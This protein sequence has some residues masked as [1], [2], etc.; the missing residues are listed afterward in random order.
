MSSSGTKVKEKTTATK[1][2]DK[3]KDEK[4][5]WSRQTGPDPRDPRNVGPPCM[6]S[7]DPAR[8]GRGSPSGSNAH[9]CWTA[10]SRCKMRLMYVPAFGAHA[11][12]RKAGALPADVEKQVQEL[13]NEAAY[14]S[15]LRDKDIGLDAAERSCMAKLEKIK[16]Q[17]AEYHKEKKS[18]MTQGP[19]VPL[20]ATVVNLEEADNAMLPGRKGRR[21][22][23]P[24]ELEAAQREE[25]ETEKS[26]TLVAP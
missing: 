25:A 20:T 5:D 2:G 4:F 24:E 1:N 21:M 19:K 16:P 6:G 12:T 9:G 10:C 17:K 26:F 15:K 23:A 8:P 22:E 3:G 14:D 18:E 13:G 11:L 7:H